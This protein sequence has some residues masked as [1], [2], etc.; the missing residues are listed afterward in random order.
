MRAIADDTGLIACPA[1][2]QCGR[3]APR[4][5]VVSRS[6]TA[7]FV[8]FDPG[9]YHIG[10]AGDGFAFDN[11]TPSHR[12][13][14][15]PF[16]LAS[17]LVTCGEYRAF[18]DDGGYTWPEL[19]LS[20]GW[21]A[22]RL[23]GWEAPLYWERSGDAWQVDRHESLYRLAV[24]DGLGHGELAAHAAA[25][26]KQTLADRPERGHVAGQATLLHRVGEGLAQHRVG[27]VYHSRRQPAGPVQAAGPLHVGVGG[28]QVAWAELVAVMEPRHLGFILA[29]WPQHAKKVVVLQIEEHLASSE[30][31]LRRI[32]EP[33]IRALLDRCDESATA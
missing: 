11:E 13:F 12:V 2:G 25:T 18:M 14:L 23:H 22:R 9:V 31:E 19:W 20:D 10:Y 8:P 1:T 28:R 6:E 7:T 16:A 17:R 32:L 15:E 4:D 33:K 21:A 24:I 27:V 29:N 3:L 5:D 30:R 26:A